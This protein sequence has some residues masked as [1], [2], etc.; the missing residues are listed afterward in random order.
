MLISKTVCKTGNPMFKRFTTVTHDN[1]W[2]RP[3][4][5]RSSPPRRERE[6]RFMGASVIGVMRH[7]EAPDSPD[8][9][10]PSLLPSTPRHPFFSG[11]SSL[12][13]RS[14]LRGPPWTHRDDV[15]VGEYGDIGTPI[16]ENPIVAR[17]DINR[18]CWGKREEGRG[19]LIEKSCLPTP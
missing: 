19:K 11:A 6:Q 7:V 9:P 17:T 4:C 15:S 13:G 10:C 1:V 3:L 18:V 14:L 16:T 8:A 2:T 12:K 5:A